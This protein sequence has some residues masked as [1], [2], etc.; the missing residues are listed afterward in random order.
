ME[1]KE[2]L[3]ILNNSRESY[4]AKKLLQDNDVLFVPIFVENSYSTVPSIISEGYSY[5]G[6]EDIRVFISLSNE[7]EENNN[8]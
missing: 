5:K 4:K 1:R 6:I 7:N 3:L 8:F 2:P